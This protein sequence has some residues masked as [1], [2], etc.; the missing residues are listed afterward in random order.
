VILTENRHPPDQ[1]E[2]MLFGITRRAL[3]RGVGLPGQ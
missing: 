1:V 3:C 2:D